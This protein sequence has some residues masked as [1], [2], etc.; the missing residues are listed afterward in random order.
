MEEV[1]KYNSLR[2][3]LEDLPNIF[4][5]LEEEAGNEETEATE[6]TAN[7][8]EGPSIMERINAADEDM[9]LKLTE[10]MHKT[11]CKKKGKIDTEYAFQLNALRKSIAEM[12]EGN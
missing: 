12:H 8:S 3:F 2:E 10:E 11:I 9:F 6:D 7:T 5:K 1:Y 4:A